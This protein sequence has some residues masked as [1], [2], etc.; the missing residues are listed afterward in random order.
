MKIA[1]ASDGKVVAEHFGHCE[2]FTIF[3]VDKEK[4]IDTEVIANPGHKPGFLPEFL[5][6]M[7]IEVIIS[8]GMGQGAVDIFNQREIEVVIGASGEALIAV[9]D[10]LAGHLESSGLICEEHR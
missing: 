7:G 6:D 10:Y 2:N 1:V 9:K 5:N 4:V 8:G 3:H